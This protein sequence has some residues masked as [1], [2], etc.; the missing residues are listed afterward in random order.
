MIA[1]ELLLVLISISSILFFI[2]ITVTVI[3]TI[4]IIFNLN[5]SITFIISIIDKNIFFT[6]VIMILII[7]VI[8]IIVIIG[9]IIIY[10]F[11][12]VSFV[13]SFIRPS[14]C[15]SVSWCRKGGKGWIRERSGAKGGGRVGKIKGKQIVFVVKSAFYLLI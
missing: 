5:T 8:S 4:V 15:L 10:T 7:I 2:N 1:S 9:T 11:V 6:T 14:F 13:L 12:F 3:Y